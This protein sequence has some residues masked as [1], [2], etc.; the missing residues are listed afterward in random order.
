MSGIARL[1]NGM[2]EGNELIFLRLLVKPS[3]VFIP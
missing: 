2:D 1:G 3:G